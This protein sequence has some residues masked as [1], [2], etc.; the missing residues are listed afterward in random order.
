[1]DKGEKN[2]CLGVVRSEIGIMERSKSELLWG[3]CR[4]IKWGDQ[5][6]ESFQDVKTSFSQ[7]KKKMGDFEEGGGKSKSRK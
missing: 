3:E 6:L 1:M 7:S 2:E 4:G 5:F